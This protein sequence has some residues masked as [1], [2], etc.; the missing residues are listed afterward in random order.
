ML[1]AVTGGIYIND[2]C[3]IKGDTTG[4]ISARTV[5]MDKSIDV[6][7]LETARGGIIRSGLAYDLCD[8]GILTNLSEDHLG[9][10]EVYTLED[11]LHI[12]SLVIESIKTKR[13]CCIK[14]R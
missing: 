8:I 11:L 7:V 12:K 1:I 13:I 14:C 2:K 5:L 4:P 6:A 3:L 9:I 10:D